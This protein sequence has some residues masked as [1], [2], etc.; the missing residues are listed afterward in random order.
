MMSRTFSVFLL[1][2]T[3][4][5]TLS[6]CAT[7]DYANTWSGISNAVCTITPTPGSDVRGTVNFS[8]VEGG[9]LVTA[10]ITGLTPGQKHGFHVHQHAYTGSSDAKC[11]G[12]HYDPE[13]TGFHAL[14]G[15]DGAHHA[16]DM[17]VLVA[18]G[19]GRAM[20]EAMIPGMSV[21]GKNAVMGRAIIIHAKP[22]DGGQPTGNAGSRI[23][24]GNIGIAA[25]Q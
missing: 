22:D 6:G 23:G 25:S 7:L 11:T 14:P 10:T 2:L 15:F 9:V 8:D 17:G 13:G 1:T 4:L 16:G 20:Y 5:G 3:T 24:V 18:D 19:N 21:A 12:G